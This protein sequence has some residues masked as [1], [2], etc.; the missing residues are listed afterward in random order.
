MWNSGFDPAYSSNDREAVASLVTACRDDHRSFDQLLDAIAIVAQGTP[1]LSRLLAEVNSL[2]PRAALTKAELSAL[3]A[4]DPDRAV[5]P[6]DLTRGIRSICPDWADT[7]RYQAL[8]GLSHAVLTLLDASS[9]QDGL[10]NVLRFVSWLVQLV[11]LLEVDDPLGLDR[12][13]QDWVRRVAEAHGLS[14]ADSQAPAA[15]S[16]APVVLVELRP[17]VPDHFGV[18]LSVWLSG[19][20]IRRLDWDTEACRLADLSARV[21]E[22]IEL[23]NEEAIGVAGELDFE[24]ALSPDIID[25]HVDWWMCGNGE[26]DLPRRL[27]AKYKV[28]VRAPRGTAT[29]RRDW[30]ARW[31]AVRQADR[32]AADL[33]LWAEEAEVNGTGLKSQLHDQHRI[34]IGPFGSTTHLNG[35]KRRLFNVAIVNG[36]PVALCLRGDVAASLAQL[37]QLKE[38]LGAARVADLPEL[39]CHWRSEAEDSTDPHFGRDLVL[40]WDDYERRPPGSRDK[41]TLP[42]MRGTS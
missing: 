37:G 19:S 3:L 24:F 22:L 20:E 31:L 10:R 38:K 27:G 12:D 35:A 36:L 30:A 14:S 25:H 7:G 39:V 9:V 26:Y 2:L 5:T 6:A 42:A 23:A 28:A 34:L 18:S 29:T 32:P 1:E 16:G 11:R 17:T 41:L 40:L 15:P 4:L 33:A 8:R 13:L 21:D